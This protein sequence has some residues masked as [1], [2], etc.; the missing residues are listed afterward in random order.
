MK[1]LARVFVP[2][3]SSRRSKGSA[4]FSRAIQHPTQEPPVLVANPRI[5]ARAGPPT[6]ATSLLFALSPTPWPAKP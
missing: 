2:L 6:P 5:C 4:A 3:V 1:T